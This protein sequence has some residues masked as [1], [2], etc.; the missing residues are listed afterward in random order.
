MSAALLPLSRGF[1]FSLE[2][3]THAKCLANQQTESA[4]AS[5]SAM[6]AKVTAT[7]GNAT[8]TFTSDATLAAIY[9]KQV[10]WSS[11]QEQSLLGL[12]TRSQ[13]AANVSRT[14]EAWETFFEWNLS[15]YDAAGSY[16]KSVAESLDQEAEVLGDQEIGQLW[17]QLYAWLGEQ[18]SLLEK[19]LVD[20]PPGIADKIMEAALVELGIYGYFM[21]KDIRESVA[22]HNEAIPAAWEQYRQWSDQVNKQSEA[23]MQSFHEQLDKMTGPVTDGQMSR[24]NEQLEEWIHQQRNQLQQGLSARPEGVVGK[25]METAD[26]YLQSLRDQLWS[27]I[28]TAIKDYHNSLPIP[29]PTTPPANVPRPQ[30]PTGSLFG[31]QQRNERFE[32]GTGLHRVVLALRSTSSVKKA[33]TLFYVVDALGHKKAVTMTFADSRMQK[34][35]EERFAKSSLRGTEVTW[36]KFQRFL[37]SLKSSMRAFSDVEMQR[38]KSKIYGEQE[39]EKLDRIVNDFLLVI[40]RMKK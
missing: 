25:I 3:N 28:Q 11:G 5:A 12:Y 14:S 9:E 33:D 10:S 8:A 27:G 16:T 7:F 18:H 21:W 37:R 4:K 20:A 19:D 26:E 35:F 2:S 15:L 34:E 30:Y 38:L 17:E 24:M 36:E 23:Y 22:A 6:S 29:T 13:A 31:S 32:V 39:K 1:S 40:K